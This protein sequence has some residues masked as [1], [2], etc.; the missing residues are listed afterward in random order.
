MLSK[1]SF[2]V[3]FLQV[4][5]PLWSRP[6]DFS[7]MNLPVERYPDIAPPRITVA[8]TYT[9]ASA[10]TVEE[11]VTQVLEQQIKGID[12]LLYF[13]SSSDSSGRSRISISFENGTD[14]DT[15]QVQVQNAINGVLNRLPDDVQRQGVNVFKS[16]GDTHM[17]IGLYDESRRSSNIELSDYLTTHLEQD[18]SRID[19]IGEVDVLVHSSRCA[20][21]WIQQN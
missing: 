11:S 20:S 2:I 3:L 7:V 10:E 19:G 4:Y 6:L 17:V 16:L 18:I 14:P 15:A 5:W 9:G 13:S 1:F 12:R 8:T 21:G